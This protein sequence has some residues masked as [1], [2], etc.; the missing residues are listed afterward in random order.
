MSGTA[1]VRQVLAVSLLAAGALALAAPDGD[2]W[3]WS[4]AEVRQAV[5]Q[6]RAGRDLT[7]AAWPDGA[8]VAVL[9]SFDVDNET[10]HGLRDGEVSIGPLSEGEYGARRALPRILELLDARDVPASFFVPAWSLKLAPEQ[11]D[12]ILAAEE[13]HEIAV[14]G[15]I[16]ERNAD[17]DAATERDLVE[18]ALATLTEITGRR[19]VG[20]RA[21][22]WNFSPNTL[23]IVRDLGFA[24]ESSLMAD[25]RPYELLADGEPTGLVELPVSWAL[26][27]APLLNPLGARYANPRDVMQVWIDEFDRAHAEGTMFLLTMHPHRIGHR[28]RIVALEGLLDHIATKE[29]VWFGTHAEAAAWVRAQAGLD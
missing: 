9:L 22:S 23:A 1:I 2:P 13:G 10:V 28:S 24:Y 16:H 7:P 15:W 3:T 4:D 19:P 21:P 17:L 29:G 11:A 12:R 20:Y 6:V 5:Y 14:H 8:R 25:D 27:D 26:D 18:R